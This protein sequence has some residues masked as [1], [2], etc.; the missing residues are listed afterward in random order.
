MQGSPPRDRYSSTSASTLLTTYRIYAGLPTT[1]KILYM[2]EAPHHVTDTLVY[3]PHHVSDTLVYTVLPT[4]CPSRTSSASCCFSFQPERRRGKGEA[5]G[6]TDTSPASS[7]PSPSPGHPGRQ[8]LPAT[9]LRIPC[10]ALPAPLSISPQTT[11]SLALRPRPLQGAARGRPR[12]DPTPPS[13][14]SLTSL[15]NDRA[16][17]EARRVAQIASSTPHRTSALPQ[18]CR[19]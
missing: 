7:L 18:E 15:V 9:P 10:S 2:P 14:P 6:P 19:R 11:L 12:P 5:C 1:C 8:P 17:V 4:T 13:A 16:E 3:T